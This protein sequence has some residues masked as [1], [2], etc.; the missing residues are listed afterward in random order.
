[1][2]VSHMYSSTYY[3]LRLPVTTAQQFYFRYNLCRVIQQIFFAGKCL[4][5]SHG[6]ETENPQYTVTR[7]WGKCELFEGV[8]ICIKGLFVFISLM[9]YRHLV[10]STAVIF[11]EQHKIS[12]S[13]THIEFSENAM[14]FG[15]PKTQTIFFLLCVPMPDCLSYAFREQRGVI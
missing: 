5:W 2:K 13:N 7:R 14:A 12:L 1:M 8:K 6:Q 15:V 9:V 4:E 11:L 10:E 3:A